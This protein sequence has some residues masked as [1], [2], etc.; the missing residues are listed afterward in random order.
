MTPTPARWLTKDQQRSWRAYLTGSARLTE[1]LNRDLESAV[2]LS[3]TEYELLVRLSEAPERRMRMAALA[4]S[5]VHSRSRLTHTIARL[6]RRGFV[7]R[8]P[9]PG[10]GRGV[11]A[12][13]RDDGYA[14]LV[15]AAP[16]HVASV[17]EHLVDVLTPEQL[18]VLGEAFEA[19]SVALSDRCPD[20]E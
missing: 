5:V 15:A 4:E 14:A 3:L 13:L 19:V 17:R 20:E 10:D 18:T 6:E 1:A 2:G 7:E 8:R 16:G 12:V 11:E 9:C